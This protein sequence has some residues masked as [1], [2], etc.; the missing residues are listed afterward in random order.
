MEF[1]PYDRQ[2]ANY[3]ERTCRVLNELEDRF[4]K[5]EI[6]QTDQE[7]WCVRVVVM[8]DT[9]ELPLAALGKTLADAAERMRFVVAGYA[10]EDST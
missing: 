6:K 7:E 8:D 4:G 9:D 1:Q 5:V 3:D 10:E 2:T